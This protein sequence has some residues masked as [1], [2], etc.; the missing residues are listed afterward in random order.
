MA[1]SLFAAESLVGDYLDGRL[2]PTAL[3]DAVVQMAET[4]LRDGLMP[5]L[6]ETMCRDIDGGATTSSPLWSAESVVKAAQ[7][8]S[9][10]LRTIP[11]AL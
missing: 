6:D 7:A 8:R 9:R 11:E 4:R 3:H 2:M 5:V 1:L 10:V